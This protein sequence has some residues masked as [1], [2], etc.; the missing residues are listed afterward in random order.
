MPR[1]PGA[2]IIRRQRAD[3]STTYSLR[4]PHGGVDARVPLGNTTDGWDEARVQR[5]REQLLAKI[6]LGLWTPT[7]ARNVQ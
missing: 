6:K 2:Q 5:A 3:H 1:R 7:L 4:V